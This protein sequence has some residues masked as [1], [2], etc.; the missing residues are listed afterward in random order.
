MYPFLNLD[1][2]NFRITYILI[3]GSNFNISLVGMYG[4]LLTIISKFLASK[5]ILSED[6]NV[7][8][9]SNVACMT[10]TLSCKPSL[11]QFSFVKSQACGLVSTAIHF[12]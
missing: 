4:G 5:F 3:S 6:F 2:L 11:L 1:D 7:P 12:T 10:V 9:S 8:S